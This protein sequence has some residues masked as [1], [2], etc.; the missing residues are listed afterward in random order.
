MAKIELFTK[1]VNETQMITDYEHLAIGKYL[2]ILEL[3]KEEDNDIAIISALSDKTEDELLNMPLTEYR[4]LRDG[5]SFLFTQP[6]PAKVRKVYTLAGQELHLLRKPEKLTTAQY[7]DFKEYAKTEETDICRYLSIVLVPEGKTY[8]DGYDVD[9]IRDIIAERLPV[10][11]ALGIRDFFVMR[12]GRLTAD[13]L[14]YSRKLAARMK[15]P[16][17]RAKTLTRI[18]EVQG[19]LTSGA[20]C[21]MWTS[22]LNSPAALGVKYMR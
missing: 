8:N 3:A 6:E 18:A 16:K 15:D 21:A 7:I 9:E 11:E 19:F 2:Q 14:T 5:A 10:T 22:L 1:K 13:S 20:G 4:T 12:L 17:K